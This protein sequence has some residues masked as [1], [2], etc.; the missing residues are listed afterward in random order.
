MVIAMIIIASESD[1]DATGQIGEYQNQVLNSYTFAEGT[2]FYIEKSTEY[3]LAQTVAERDTCDFES[4]EFIKQFANNFNDNFISNLPENNAKLKRKIYTINSESMLEQKNHTYKFS[5][6]DSVLI[7][8]ST[9]PITVTNENSY[10]YE[11]YK[12]STTLYADF[13]YVIDCDKLEKLTE[14]I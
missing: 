3:A 6:K 2:R 14:N 5:I 12:I 1:S 9:E 8:D 13:E 7:A 4:N 11:K 10:T